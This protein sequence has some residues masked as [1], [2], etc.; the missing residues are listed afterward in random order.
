MGI[1]AAIAGQTPSAFSART[2]TVL[3]RHADEFTVY[4]AYSVAIPEQVFK[5]PLFKLISLAYGTC[6]TIGLR[7]ELPNIFVTLPAR[8]QTTLTAMPQL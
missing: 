6:E 5:Y 7:P 2:C 3:P 1:A 8:F 4:T